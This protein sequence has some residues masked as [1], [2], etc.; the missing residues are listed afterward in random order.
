MQSPT[1][2]H[3][4]YVEQMYSST[5]ENFKKQSASQKVG[6]KRKLTTPQPFEFA[7]SKRAKLFDDF[8]EQEQKE[9]Y[10][11]LCELVKES[12][13]LRPDNNRK[14]ITNIESMLYATGSESQ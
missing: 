1:S 14:D 2:K 9:T 10:K 13:T 12:F 11:P 8:E 5:I 3:L 7:T 4:K 6:D